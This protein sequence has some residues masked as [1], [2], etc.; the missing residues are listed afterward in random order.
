MRGAVAVTAMVVHDDD[1]DED[2]G[3]PALA[4]RVPI[5]GD[6]I[7]DPDNPIAGVVCPSCATDE[8][9]ARWPGTES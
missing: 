9:Q 4:W 2:Y 7:P 1:M 6:W 5:P 3:D 8:E